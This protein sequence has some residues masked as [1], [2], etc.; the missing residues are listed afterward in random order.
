MT[1]AGSAG[2]GLWVGVLGDRIQHDHRDVVDAAGAVRGL[3]QTVGAALRVGLGLQ[4]RRD[5]FLG[6]HVGEPVAAQQD[7][8]AIEQRDQVFVDR[9]LLGRADG[10]GDDV[11]LGVH[12][13]LGLG[14]LARLHHAGDE[15]VVVGQLAERARPHQVGAAV[16]DVGQPELAAFLQRRRSGWCP[17]RCTAES[18]CERS[19]T[20]R[21]ACFTC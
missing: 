10:M 15:R 1:A 12:L 18:S 11:A 20:A 14:D 16:P 9:D 19:N 8:V 5:L 21:L 3:D 13:R 4:D 17:C 6:H 2:G 7:T